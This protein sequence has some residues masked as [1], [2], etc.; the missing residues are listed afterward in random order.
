MAP[1]RRQSSRPPTIGGAMQQSQHPAVFVQ[2]NEADANRVIALRRGDDGSLS[3]LGSYATGG[4][5]DGTPHL[6]SQGS[7]ALTRDGLHLLVTNAGSGEVSIFA[8]EDGGLS[9]VDTVATGPAPK[10]IA[11]HE[12]I[13]YVLNTADASL[14]GFR[15]D[16]REPIERRSLAEGADPAQVGFSPDGSTLVVTDRGTNAIVQFPVGDSGRLG[17]AQI[18]P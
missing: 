7:V 18:S 6:T 16:N 1:F 2:T 11:E 17:E 14:A 9:L 12:G 4:A 10:S 15:L 3:E 13:V 8:V 5:G